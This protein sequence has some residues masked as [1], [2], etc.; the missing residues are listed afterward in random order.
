[1]SHLNCSVF[2]AG[3][4]GT[5]LALHL[6]RCGHN[7]TLVPRRLDVAL[8][9]TRDRENKERLPG[10]P[11]P[12]SLQIGHDV[13][14]A[15]QNADVIFMACPS[16][17]LRH[18]ARHL[19]SAL[20]QKENRPPCV[21]LCKGLEADTF[22]APAR[23]L[24]EE[25]SILPHAAL[26][27]PSHADDV[28]QGR[29]TALVLAHDAKLL[30]EMKALC[31]AIS[32]KSLRVYLSDDVTGVELG[33]TL[34][35]IY[36]IGAG[37]CDGTKLGDNAKAAYLTRC[38]CEMTRVGTALGGKAQT[39]HGL[40]GFGDL[41]ATCMGKWSRNRSFGEDLLRGATAN[42]GLSH[43]DGVVEGYIAAK[44]FYEL[45]QTRGI[46]APILSGIYAVLYKSTDPKAEMLAL[47][48]RE[49]KSEC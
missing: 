41:V 9:L 23:V 16:Q 11:L 39:F 12:Y 32:D 28:A 37:L 7:V 36:A 21:T 34:K 42:E 24:A 33:G 29:P 5:A 46:D 22:K 2:G 47:M 40:S 25:L 35:N 18:L 13:G 48:S 3:A 15:L 10:H 1:M 17:A 20:Q 4:W 27:G 45:A 38:L 8:A 49:I 6:G 19:A 30:P 26:S 31:A 14:P 44:C 43:S